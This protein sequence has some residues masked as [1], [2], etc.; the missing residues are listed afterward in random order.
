[1]KNKLFSLF[2]ALQISEV[3]LILLLFLGG[4]SK[5]QTYNMQHSSSNL[6]HNGDTEFAKG[7]DEKPSP[8]T[9]YFMADILAAQGKDEECGFLLKRCIYEYPR[10]VPAYNALAELRMRQGQIKES[11]QI[12]SR[13]LQVYPRDVV[14]LNNLGMC[15]MIRQEYAQALELFT[16]AAG[17]SPENSRYRANMGVALGLMGR[18]DESQSLFAQVLPQEQVKKNLEILQ[19]A[20]KCPTRL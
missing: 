15:W 9:L 3:F 10:F 5:Q 13:G 12:I 2:T 6:K 4:C 16:T 18:Y 17:I 20:E 19:D 8:E 11:I 7:S 1:M 14:L